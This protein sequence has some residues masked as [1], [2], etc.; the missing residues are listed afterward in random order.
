MDFG[1]HIAHRGL[2]GGGVPEN[3]MTAF[4]KAI[5][6]GLPIELDVRLTKDAKVVVLHD[7]RLK[8]MCG[9]DVRVCDLTY[10][11]LMK[12]TLAET[13]E[14]IPLFKDVLK[15]VD[16]R[17][18]LLVELKKGHPLGKLEN[19]TYHLLKQYKGE[20]AVQSFHPLIMFWFR[21]HAPEIYRGILV[22]VADD[23]E[24]FEN[25]SSH[26]GAQPFTW[27]FSKPDF[28]SCDVELLSDKVAEV[29]K[30]MKADLYSWTIN[31]DVLYRKAAKYSK[32]LICERSDDGFDF[33]V[34]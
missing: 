29:V 20:Y 3:S 9:A 33:T 6:L 11:E 15:L 13:D 32:T 30:K 23:C 16:G 28:V 4:K 7:M 31:S 1:K 25:I 26:L 14:H 21:L 34:K 10:D 5:E 24:F 22:T 17:V 12:Y 18:P 2:H 19:R 8:R 27:R